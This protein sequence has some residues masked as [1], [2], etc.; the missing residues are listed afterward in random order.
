MTIL[1]RVENVKKLWA[2][3]LSTCPAPN[4]YN[5]ARWVSRFSDSEID[6]AV[7]RTAVRFR[8]GLPSDTTLVHRYAT[9]ILLNE[10]TKKGKAA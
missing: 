10:Q 2:L 6:Y 1:D 9:G 7:G 8:S 4:D 3:L 5:V